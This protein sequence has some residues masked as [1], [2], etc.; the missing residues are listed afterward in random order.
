M[1]VNNRSLDVKDICVMLQSLKKDLEGNLTG[2]IN[3]K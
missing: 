1:G 3:L 2:Q